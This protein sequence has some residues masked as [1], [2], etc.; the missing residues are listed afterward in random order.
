M[1]CL[2]LEQEVV[3]RWDTFVKRPFK[4]E[5]M[6]TGFQFGWRHVE[7]PNF[8]KYHPEATRQ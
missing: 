3:H 2:P 1:A 6:E 4:M 5:V 7:R 8:Y